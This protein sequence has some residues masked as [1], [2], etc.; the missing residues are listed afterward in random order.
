VSRDAAIS[1]YGVDPSAERMSELLR[2]L[3]RREGLG[4]DA[5]AAVIRKAGC[6]P[7]ATSVDWPPDVVPQLRRFVLKR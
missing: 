3:C 7:G 5:V 6:E 2:E 1:D 4:A